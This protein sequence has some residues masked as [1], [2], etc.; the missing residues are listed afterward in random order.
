MWWDS[1]KYQIKAYLRDL[2]GATGLEI[3]LK[4][5]PNHPFFNSC[6]FEHWWIT[7][8]NHWAPLIY[9]IKAL[10]IISNPSVN[11][12]WSYRP[13]TLNSGQN[14]QCFCPVRPWIWWM[15][16]KTIA[17][18]FYVAW[19]FVHHFTTIT[20]FKLE[21]QSGNAQFWSESTIFISRVTLKFG[22]WPLKKYGTSPML[23][24]ALCIIP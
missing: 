20:V 14:R 1:I 23:L 13:E 16:L 12:N 4:F 6:D 24:Q 7:S 15:T 11:S 10:C 19:S 2:I 18:L 3:L 9:Y 17:H 8:K 22:K 21:L 5:N